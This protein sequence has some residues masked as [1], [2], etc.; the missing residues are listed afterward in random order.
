[1]NLITEQKEKKKKLSVSVALRSAEPKPKARAKRD[2]IARKIAQL[3]MRGW[4]C[5]LLFGAVREIIKKE[6]A[7]EP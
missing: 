3:N 4:R 6:F 1:M 2:L 5:K 7:I